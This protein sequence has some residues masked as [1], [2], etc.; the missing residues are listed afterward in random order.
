MPRGLLAAWLP[1][2]RVRRS[3]IDFTL[4]CMFPKYADWD[5][6]YTL[7]GRVSQVFATIFR[8]GFFVL[9]AAGV[10]IFRISGYGLRNLTQSI[11]STLMGALE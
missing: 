7:N 2:T 9:L 3:Q 1:S 8:N 6:A 5:I 10:L 4:R 11:L